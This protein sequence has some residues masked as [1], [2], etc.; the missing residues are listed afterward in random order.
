MSCILRWGLFNG[1]SSKISSASCVKQGD[2]LSPRLFNLF[3]DDLVKKL[4]FSNCDP[5]VIKAILDNKLSFVCR[6]NKFTFRS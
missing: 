4:K 2:V 6:R 5:I 3:I 1:V